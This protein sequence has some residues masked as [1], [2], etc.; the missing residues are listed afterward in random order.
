MRIQCQRLR[1]EDDART[2]TRLLSP[3]GAW[4]LLCA[5]HKGQVSKGISIPFAVTEDSYRD[6]PSILKGQQH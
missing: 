6:W 5:K 4:L 3:P 2:V 1:C